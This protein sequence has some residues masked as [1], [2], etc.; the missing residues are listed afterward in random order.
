VSVLDEIKEEVACL[1]R[2]REHACW[3]FHNWGKWI[4]VSLVFAYGK[5]AGRPAGEGQRRD[6]ERCGKAETREVQFR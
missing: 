1:W 5:N 6:C 2:K 3:L 4:T